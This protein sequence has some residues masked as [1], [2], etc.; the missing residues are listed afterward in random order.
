[1]GGVL[2]EGQVVRAGAHESGGGLP[3][4]GGRL[5]LAGEEAYAIE[6]GGTGAELL[7]LPHGLDDV[8]GGRPAASAIQVGVAVIGEGGELFSCEARVD[9]GVSFKRSER[10]FC[11]I[12]SS[13]KTVI[14]AESGAAAAGSARIVT[15][16]RDSG[17][18]S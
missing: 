1:V 2:G 9:D 12:T 14:W 6:V 7:D 13:C 10:P 8:V 11:I 18:L 16:C 17:P 3:G 15:F 4:V 5:G